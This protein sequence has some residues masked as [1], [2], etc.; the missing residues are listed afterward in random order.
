MRGR[1]ELAKVTGYQSL[2]V[3]RPSDNFAELLREAPVAVQAVR[4][5]QPELAELA[6]RK[7][8][9]PAHKKQTLAI[10]SVAVAAIRFARSP[11]GDRVPQPRAT[12]LRSH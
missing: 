4:A 9:Y 8:A 3:A 11:W 2:S 7:F 6:E 1:A 12:D 5:A 10:H